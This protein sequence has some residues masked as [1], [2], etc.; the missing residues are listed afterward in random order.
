MQCNVGGIDRTGR[1]VVGI[2]L[3]LVGLLAPMALAWRVLVLVVA[4]IALVTGIVRYCPLNAAF[5]IDTC[6]QKKL[7]G[8]GGAG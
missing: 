4:A 3:L 7:G 5:G 2:V 6:G 8:P 1:I